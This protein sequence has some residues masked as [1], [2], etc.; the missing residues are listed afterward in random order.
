[1]N[2]Q[3]HFQ[4]IVVVCFLV[5]GLGGFILPLFPTKEGCLYSVSSILGIPMFKSTRSLSSTSSSDYD[6]TLS[7]Y[8]E[9]SESPS[10]SITQRR[11]RQSGRIRPIRHVTVSSKNLEARRS[12]AQLRHEEALNDPTLLTNDKFVDRHDIHPATKRAITEVMGLQLMTEI[13][14]KTYAVALS[15]ESILGRSRTGTS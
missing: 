8:D 15:G 1:M 7:E 11:R 10:Q 13:Q 9:E 5:D 4:W 2:S 14:S 12:E 3:H 6:A